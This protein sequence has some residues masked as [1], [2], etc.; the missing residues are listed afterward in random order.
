MKRSRLVLVVILIA[1]AALSGSLWVNEG[2]LWRIV[3]LKEMDA[4]SV[5]PVQGVVGVYIPPRGVS[6]VLRWT[7]PPRAHGRTEW[8]YPS[9]GFKMREIEY[10]Y[11]LVRK[12]TEWNSDGSVAKQFRPETKGKSGL[13][14]WWGVAPQT[15][16][17]APWWEEEKAKRMEGA[18]Q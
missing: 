9:N 5:F 7:D 17:T 4:L 10:R 8:F 16:P 3:M 18:G 6:T 15:K 2:P 13:P 1:V 14:W 11:G 12:W